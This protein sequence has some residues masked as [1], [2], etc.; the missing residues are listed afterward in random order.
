MLPVYTTEKDG[1]RR[2]IKTLDPRYD[3]PFAK[4]M[5]GTAIAAVYEKIREQV[6]RGITNAKYVAA[7]TDMWSSSTMEPYL[8]NN[9]SFHS[10]LIY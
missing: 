4:Y 5:S 1:F 8:F 2:L 3:I 9:K 7:I 6:A 10:S